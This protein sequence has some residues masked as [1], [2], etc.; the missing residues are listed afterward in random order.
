MELLP[1][2]K[3]SESLLTLKGD[4]LSLSPISQVEVQASRQSQGAPVLVGIEECLFP[5][6]A[7]ALP[8]DSTAQGM[9]HPLPTWVTKTGPLGCTDALGTSSISSPVLAFGLQIHS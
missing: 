1:S 9:S 2:K 5:T 8:V 4:F 7:I 6:K 3:A